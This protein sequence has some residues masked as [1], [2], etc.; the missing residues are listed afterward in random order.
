[1]TA[2]EAKEIL[3]ILQE[4]YKRAAKSGGVTT[5]T[6]NSG[7]GNTSVKQATLAELR[8]EINE[9]ER[10]YNELSEMEDGS[11]FT[12]IRSFGL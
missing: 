10:T 5:Y 1:M 11:N 4:A 6:L 3:L 7:Q 8:A 9:Y 2:D 12:C